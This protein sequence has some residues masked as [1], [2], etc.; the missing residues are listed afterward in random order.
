MSFST[1]ITSVEHAFAAAAKDI[2]TGAKF[3]ATGILPILQ[4]AQVAAPTIE[5]IT[6]LVS[7]AAANIERVA[8]AGL[9]V[10]IKAIDDAGSAAT[11]GGLN[12]SL[13]AQLVADIKSL[14]PTIKAAAQPV[15]PAPAPP[16]S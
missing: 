14:I 13:D 3:V 8:Y 2:V 5:A 9:G 10:I 15:T 6:N 1:I 4:K 16:A 11:G 12:V 7:P